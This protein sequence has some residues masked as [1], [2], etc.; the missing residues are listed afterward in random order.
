MKESVNKIYDEK[1]LKNMKRKKKPKTAPKA[2]M[3]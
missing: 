3:N 2:E 1:R